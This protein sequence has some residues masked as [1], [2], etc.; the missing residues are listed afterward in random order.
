MSLRVLVF[1]SPRYVFVYLNV[2]CL[3]CV[4]K[5]YLNG[6]TVEAQVEVGYP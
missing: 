2:R 4:T 1:D 6:T 3:I 5:N